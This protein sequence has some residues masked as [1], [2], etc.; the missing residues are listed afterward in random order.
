MEGVPLLEFDHDRTAL[1]EPSTYYQNISPPEGC[2]MPFYASV[3]TRLRDEG[4]LQKIYELESASVFLSPIDVYK[5]KSGNDYVSVVFPGLGA[6]LSAGLFEELISLGCKKFIACGSCGVLK[7]ELTR[8]AVVIPQSAVRD[9]GTSFHYCLPSRTIE[10]EPQVV[11][12]LE[13]VLKKHKVPY[14]I[15]KTWTTDA[16]YR[17]TKSKIDR[18]KSE[19]CITVEMECAA[20]LAVARFRGVVFGQYL[21]AGDDVS[22]EFWDPRRTSD[23]HSFQEELFWLSVEAVL[24]L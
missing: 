17:E 11:R 13:A 12:K 5:L 8:G 3:I 4:V 24:S 22:G 6:P 9:E 16:I 21:G 14:E 19:G 7:P 15:G 18:R 20:M 1:I 10:M 2:V 23:R